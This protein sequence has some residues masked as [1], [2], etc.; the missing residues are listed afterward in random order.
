[1]AEARGPGTGTGTDP[2]A[3][4]CQSL[5]ATMGAQARQVWK[6]SHPVRKAEVARCF[7]V[8]RKMHVS[9]LL[10]LVAV[11]HLHFVDKS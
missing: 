8:S 6:P 7:C 3:V 11:D 5:E 4:T 2:G 10:S 9:S 1:M